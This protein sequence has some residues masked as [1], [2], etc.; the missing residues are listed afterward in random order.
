MGGRV[1]AWNSTDAL[2]ISVQT[3]YDRKLSGC[4]KNNVQ[5]DVCY[6][7]TSQKLNIGARES[8]PVLLSLKGER[9]VWLRAPKQSRTALRGPR[10][11]PLG[12]PLQSKVTQPLPERLLRRTQKHAE[13]SGGMRRDI[14]SN[15][16]HHEAPRG[17]PKSGA[18]P[19]GDALKNVRETPVPRR[20]GTPPLRLHPNVAFDG[21]KKE[22]IL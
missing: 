13:A 2:F 11:M 7:Q 8:A 3:F 22:P 12:A 5:E 21:S 14:R 1:S 19:E 15:P 10:I 9:Q 4:R 16:K 6:V 18:A 20:P 17:P